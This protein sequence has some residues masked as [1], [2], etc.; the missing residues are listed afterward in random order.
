[1]YLNL[2]LYLT[3][4]PFKKK[5]HI[6]ITQ[7]L[8]PGP[9][10]LS[11]FLCYLNFSTFLCYL[12]FS[13]SPLQLKAKIPS[14]NRFLSSPMFSGFPFV[15]F[16]GPLVVQGCP[17]PLVVQPFIVSCINPPPQPA[18]SPSLPFSPPMLACF[19]NNDFRASVAEPTPFIFYKYF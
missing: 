16:S 12:T 6:Y 18:P 17:T 9:L 10:T 2:Y 4:S 8:I 3:F 19:A 14:V 13:T 15:V 7:M 11:T 5:T 1:M